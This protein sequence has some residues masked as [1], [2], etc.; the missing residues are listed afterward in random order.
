MLQVTNLQRGI[1]YGTQRFDSKFTNT[2][3][4]QKLLQQITKKIITEKFLK[5][6]QVRDFLKYICTYVINLL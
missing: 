5:K 4:T 1:L 3:L 6:G 2:S